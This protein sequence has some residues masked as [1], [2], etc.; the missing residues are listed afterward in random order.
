MTALRVPHPD[1]TE[2]LPPMAADSVDAALVKLG[3]NIPK[4]PK[5]TSTSTTTTPPAAVRENGFCLE[6]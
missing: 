1:D 4:P 3:V 6:L 2:P 5:P